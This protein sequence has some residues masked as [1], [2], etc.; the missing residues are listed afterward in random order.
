MWLCLTLE[1][2]VGVSQTEVGKIP[3][4]KRDSM[5]RK[6]RKN[7]T[8]LGKY[9]HRRLLIGNPCDSGGRGPGWA[10]TRDKG[11]SME[12]TKCVWGVDSFPQVLS[13]WSSII[14]QVTDVLNSLSQFSWINKY[15]E[16]YW[17]NVCP[18]KKVRRQNLCPPTNHKQ[19]LIPPSGKCP[20]K[21]LFSLPG[22]TLPGMI[23]V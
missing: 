18:L 22:R 23:C 13:C 12:I 8:R 2:W 16:T 9:V 10:G 20:K 1:K 6:V 15:S 3:S 4:Q 17:N 11:L 14:P 5:C 21:L 19:L 7:Q